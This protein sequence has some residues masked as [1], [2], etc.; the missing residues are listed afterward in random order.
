V[1]EFSLPALAE[2]PATTNLAS[3]IF[4]RAAEQ[5]QAVM[6]RR[7]AADGSWQDV[8]AGQFEAEVVAV[9]RA[10]GA[11]L[12]PPSGGPGGRTGPRTP[13]AVDILGNYTAFA[14]LRKQL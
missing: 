13:V 2:I 6:L 7:P 3:S 4:R 8:T 5:P 9:D 14:E 10:I 11:D 1:R 12:A